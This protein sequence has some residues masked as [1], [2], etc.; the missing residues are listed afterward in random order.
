MYRI[1]LSLTPTKTQL[2]QFPIDPTYYSIVLSANTIYR[3]TVRSK[4]VRGAL[5]DE[6]N[7][8]QMDRLSASTEFRTLPKG[9]KRHLHNARVLYAIFL[10]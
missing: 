8:K 10:F 9:N 5:C 3:V 1:C 4:H 7:I 6:K 2:T